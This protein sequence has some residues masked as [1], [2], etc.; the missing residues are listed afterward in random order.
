MSRAVCP[1]DPDH[2]NF[3]TVA[4]VMQEWEVDDEGAFLW[5]T[6]DC[7]EVTHFP[8]SGNMWTC[9]ACE[10]EGVDSKVTVTN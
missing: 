4:H 2:K 10:E 5:T 3:R 7:L 8:S 6:V 1:N 9:V